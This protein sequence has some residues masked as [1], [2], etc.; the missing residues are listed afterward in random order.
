[1]RL[2]PSYSITNRFTVERLEACHQ[3]CAV[4]LLLVILVVAASAEIQQAPIPV[5]SSVALT[6]LACL[7][8]TLLATDGMLHM[9]LLI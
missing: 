3:A 6:F 8:E 2:R 7:S 9:L 1:M 4:M 5:H